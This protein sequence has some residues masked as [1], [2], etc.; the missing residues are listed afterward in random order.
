MD[1]YNNPGNWEK[2]DKLCFVFLIGFIYHSKKS[3]KCKCYIRLNRIPSLISYIL[4][5]KKI[6]KDI[7]MKNGIY[8]SGG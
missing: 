4:L 3:M 2:R 6:K 1:S 5:L 7:I 8:F